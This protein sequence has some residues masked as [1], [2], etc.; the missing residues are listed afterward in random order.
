M[1]VDS[2]AEETTTGAV[3]DSAGA[4]PSVRL[5]QFVNSFGDHGFFGS[6]CAPSYDNFFMEAVGL[7]DTTCDEFTPPE[8]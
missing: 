1:N 7:I 6:V 3:A 5:R 4:E 2:T 8:G